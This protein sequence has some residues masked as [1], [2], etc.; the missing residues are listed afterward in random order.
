M[1][2][3]QESEHFNPTK[4]FPGI[5]LHDTDNDLALPLVVF[6]GNSQGK[7]KTRIHQLCNSIPHL[8][9][10][11][12]GLHWG[13]FDKEDEHVPRT[14]KTTSQTTRSQ[15]LSLFQNPHHDARHHKLQNAGLS[16]KGK[17]ELLVEALLNMLS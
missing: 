16:A 3:H 5:K 17:A 8:P 14:S 1:K 6:G 11:A 9:S 10:Q 12:S 7:L 2:I 13:H 4:A 15:E